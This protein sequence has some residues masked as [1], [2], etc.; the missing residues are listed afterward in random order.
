MAV[1]S[2]VLA[3]KIVLST[4]RCSELYQSLAEAPARCTPDGESASRSLDFP[5]LTPWDAPKTFALQHGHEVQDLQVL[6]SVASLDAV[7]KV[8]FRR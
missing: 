7:G 4:E 2:Q 6:S 1:G 5:A 8:R 3:A